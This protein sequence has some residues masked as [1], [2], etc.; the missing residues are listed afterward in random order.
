MFNT[1]YNIIRYYERQ[2]I[3]RRTTTQSVDNIILLIVVICPKYLLK[4]AHWPISTA[5]RILRKH[6]FG[7]NV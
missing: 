2:Q 4:I 7:L 1:V 5:I 3:I 6:E